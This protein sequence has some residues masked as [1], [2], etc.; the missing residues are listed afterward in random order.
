MNGRKIRGIDLARNRCSTL[1]RASIQPNC[2]K[3]ISERG[4]LGLGA[5]VLLLKT[6]SLCSS[7]KVKRHR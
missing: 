3:S 6:C 1:I 4:G 2:Y 7:I 5:Q